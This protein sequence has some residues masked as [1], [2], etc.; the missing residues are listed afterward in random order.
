MFPPSV[1]TIEPPIVVEAPVVTKQTPSQ[2]TMIIALNPKEQRFLEEVNSR[3][4][5][6]G[7]LKQKHIPAFWILQLHKTQRLVGLRLLSKSKKTRCVNVIKS[8]FFDS[9]G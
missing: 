3:L 5:K 8:P 1:A 7:L 9:L 4:S 6:F 2:Q